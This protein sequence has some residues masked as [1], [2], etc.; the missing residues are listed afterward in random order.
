[1][2]IDGASSSWSEVSS[3]VP[4]SLLGPLFFIT[5]ISD[6]PSV[7][8]PG[9]TIALYARITVKAHESDSAEDLELFQQDLV[10]F[11]WWSMLNGM[12]FNVKKCKIMKIT[13]KKKPFT[14][15]FF[16]NN[17]ELE[18]VDEFK[19]LGVI[20]VHH[21]RYQRTPNDNLA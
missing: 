10:N 7:V 2:L 11:V 19:V 14:S 12:E 18:E 8:L 21:L 5:F 13:R 20:T 3:G 6:L 4:G 1:M 15:T 17:T 9:N 16:L